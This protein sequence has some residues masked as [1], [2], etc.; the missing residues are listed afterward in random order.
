M[1]GLA[2]LE[3]EGLRALLPPEVAQ[4]PQQEGRSAASLGNRVSLVSLNVDGLGAY[5]QTP[6]ARI[7][8]ALGRLLDVA[9]DVILL[10][11]VSVE[12]FRVAQAVLVD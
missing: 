6:A 11:E 7:A 5:D 1:E 10:Q 4:E 8:T 3:A 2:F 12:M 9:P